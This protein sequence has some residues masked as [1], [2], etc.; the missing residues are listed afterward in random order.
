[1]GLEHPL[2]LTGAARRQVG[3]FIAA[4]ETIAKEHPDAAAY[5]PGPIL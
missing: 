3:V 5:S 2:D 1:V 4:A